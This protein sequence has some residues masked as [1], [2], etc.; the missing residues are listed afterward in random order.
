MHGAI[1]PLPNTPSWRGAQFKRSTGTS[2]PSTFILLNRA[3]RIGKTLRS[4]LE[5]ETWKYIWL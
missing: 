4:D 2:L 3:P 1:P 5:K